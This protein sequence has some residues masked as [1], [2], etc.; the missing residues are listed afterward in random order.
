MRGSV[1]SGS[2]VGEIS[3]VWDALL[4]LREHLTPSKGSPTLYPS[5]CSSSK[6]WYMVR[7]GCISNFFLSLP[8]SSLL[9][10]PVAFAF[11]THTEFN[12]SIQV[13]PPGSLVQVRII[14]PWIG[15]GAPH[16]LSWAFPA[17]HHLKGVL[18]PMDFIPIAYGPSPSARIQDRPCCPALAP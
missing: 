7:D 14:S 12:H 6:L 18:P 9:W 5:K 16:W 13:P 3:F 2:L 8:T 17:C 4:S 15:A 11:R 1:Y 10:S